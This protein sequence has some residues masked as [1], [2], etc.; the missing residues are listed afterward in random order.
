MSSLEGPKSFLKNKWSL[1]L[2]VGLWTFLLSGS[3]VALI[4]YSGKPGAPA[5]VLKQW[6]VKTALGPLKEKPI[7]A[8]FLHPHCPC[9]RATLN[10]LDR[11]LPSMFGKVDVRLVFIQPDG[12]DLEW[13][14]SSLWKKAIALPGVQVLIDPRGSEIDRFGPKVSGHTMFFES[15]GK[16]IF[17]GGLTPSRGHGGDSP[18]HDFLLGWMDGK[19]PEPLLSSIFGCGLKEASPSDLTGDRLA[20]NHE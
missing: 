12:R 17:S 7:L 10:E 15:T 16:L 20:V 2:V 5:E 18:G 13:V 9:S 8:V 1:R 6:P 3:V 14:H 11:L 19:R 4:K